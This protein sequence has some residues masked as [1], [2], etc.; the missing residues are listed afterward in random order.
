MPTNLP[1]NYYSIDRR[2]KTATSDTEKITCL[3][4]MMSIIPKHK[5]TDKIRADIRKRLSKIRNATQ[6]KKS[7]SKKDLAFII[8]KEGAGQVAVVG[9]PNV[10]KSALVSL[11]TNSQPEISAAPFTTWK[12]T[13]GMMDYKDI[14]IQLIDTPSLNSDY[15]DTGMF[16][17]I[18]RSD[19]ILCL[20]DIQADAIDQLNRSIAILKDHK[21]V[22]KRLRHLYQEH[23]NI[24]FLPTIIGLNKFDDNS[25]QENIEIFEAFLDDQEWPIVDCS[26]LNNNNMDAL[27]QMIFDRLEIVRVYAKS[28]GKPVDKTAPFVLKKNSNVGDFASKVHKD[29]EKNMKTA[30]VWRVGVFDGQTVQKDHILHDDDI[31]EINS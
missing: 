23:R 21:I 20:V 9:A 30:K 27:K 18:R 24:Q 28:P 5:G 3:E 22:P 6:S 15:I 31:V 8:E 1:P 4:E 29:I 10:G 19:M 25:F 17:L 14:K 12:P 2:Y 16:D 13:P 7:N 26:A 11:L